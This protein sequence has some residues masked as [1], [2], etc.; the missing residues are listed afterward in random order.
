MIMF[1]E[2]LDPRKI[3][4]ISWKVWVFKITIPKGKKKHL[5]N[6]VFEVYWV[7]MKRELIKSKAMDL[8][9]SKEIDLGG[10]GEIKEKV[11]CNY[12]HKKLNE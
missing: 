6:L 3:L 5:I 4:D 11:I 8:K 12:N 9:Q 10:P 2:Y 1:H 7:Y